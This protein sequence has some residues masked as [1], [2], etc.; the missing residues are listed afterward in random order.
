M[1]IEEAIKVL[2]PFKACMFDQYGCPISDAAIALDVAIE[3]LQENESLA[4]S[5]NDAAEL[6]HKLQKKNEWIPCSERLPNDGHNVLMCRKNG[7]VGEGCYHSIIGE[8]SQFRWNASG[9]KGV[10]AWMEMPEPYKENES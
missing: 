1:T 3:A 10:I 5:V 4:K 9:V 2:E 7:T 8:W 6:I